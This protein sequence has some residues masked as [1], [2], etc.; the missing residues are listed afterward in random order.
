MV[1]ST[2]NSK[3]LEGFMDELRSS[4]Q[5]FTAF[6][7]KIA[8]PEGMAELLGKLEQEAKNAVANLKLMNSEG[9]DGEMIRKIRMLLESDELRNH[10]GGIWAVPGVLWNSPGYEGHEVPD[11]QDRF[12]SMD[13]PKRER[14]HTEEAH[15]ARSS[16]A[17]HLPGQGEEFAAYA[18][19]FPFFSMPDEEE[20]K[21]LTDIVAGIA[22][23]RQIFA[24][25]EPA[26]LGGNASQ[27]DAVK[28]FYGRGDASE[29]IANINREWQEFSGKL[30]EFAAALKKA[31]LISFERN[32]EEFRSVWQGMGGG[33]G[34][35]GAPAY[36][37]WALPGFGQAGQSSLHT[38][39]EAGYASASQNLR[40]SLSSSAGG[41]ALDGVKIWAGLFE[42]GQNPALVVQGQGGD[43]SVG[44]AIN[45]IQLNVDG[46]SKATERFITE[47][48]SEGID[49]AMRL[50]EKL[51][52]L[53]LEPGTAM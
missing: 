11:A 22:A 21:A 5:A 36:K 37:E 6:F 53:S 39:Q 41:A 19:G 52:P 8:E 40:R 24:S 10:K 18:T 50:Q 28:R 14:A 38:S 34:Y 32:I 3:D 20:G 4:V 9:M 51:D 47:R 30:A 46:G 29:E 13:S 42:N 33:E 44:K 26:G 31:I 12:P 2:G 43:S 17:R 23:L 15:S 1:Q 7:R 48:I 16:R 35:M 45:S 27:A 49:L 25:P